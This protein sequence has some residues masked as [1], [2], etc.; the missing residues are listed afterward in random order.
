VFLLLAKLEPSLS[1]FPKNALAHISCFGNYFEAHVGAVVS[2]SRYRPA[3]QPEREYARGRIARRAACLVKSFRLCV[4]GTGSVGFMP[5]RNCISKTV[6]N[7][8]VVAALAISNTRSTNR[9]A[10]NIAKA[11]AKVAD[12]TRWPV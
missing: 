3:L 7:A 12:V 10:P 5:G 4:H 1:A 2:A 8:L 11:R 9:L 6:S